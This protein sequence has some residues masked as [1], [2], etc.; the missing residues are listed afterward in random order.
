MWRKSCT[1]IYI[2][3]ESIAK[4]HMLRMAVKCLNSNWRNRPTTIDSIPKAVDYVISIDENGTSNLKKVL[5]AKKTKQPVPES[6]QHFTV[7]ACLMRSS[8]LPTSAQMVMHLKRRYWHNA[9]FSYNGEIKRVCLHSKEIR[10]HK[11]AFHPRVIDYDSFI[12]DLS[13]LIEDLP[14]TI[15]TSHIDKARHVNHYAYPD[16]PYDLC[17]HFVLERIMKDMGKKEKCI[18][19]LE[20]RGKKEDKELLDQIKSLIDH[21][22]RYNPSSVFSKIVGVYFNSKWSQKDSFQKSYWTLEI[23]DVCSYPVYKYF[24]HGTRDRAYEIVEAKMRG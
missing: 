10:G 9:L 4:Y 19:V 11:D 20:S 22:N 21:G 5:Q 8:D 24:T 23:A 15:Y 1:F 16:S 17:M 18:V 2:V 7:T 3:V 6:E 13:Q 14:M 12:L